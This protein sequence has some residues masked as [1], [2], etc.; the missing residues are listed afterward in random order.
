[1]WPA[2]RGTHDEVTNMEHQLVIFDLGDEYYG[3][4]IA[5]VEGIIKMQGITTV[6]HAP[7]FVEGVINLRGEVLPVI[8]LRKRFG[9]PPH[10]AAHETRIVVVEMDGGKAGVIVDDVS[11]VLRVPEEAIEPPSPIVAG[12]E[13]GM[14]MGIAKVDDRLIIL[15][16]MVRMLTAEE[17]A[18]MQAMTVPA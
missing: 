11:E 13:S 8:D 9:L 17:Q 12:A 18:A 10:E 15:L 16:D 4:D 2:P 7:E 3:I 5:A 1:M 14:I 6:P